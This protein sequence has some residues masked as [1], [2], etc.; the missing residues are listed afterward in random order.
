VVGSLTGLIVFIGIL[1][2]LYIDYTRGLIWFKR[3]EVT[4][5]TPT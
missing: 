3:I 4:G 2:V 5:N 1:A